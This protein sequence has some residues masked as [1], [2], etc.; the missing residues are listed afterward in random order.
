MNRIEPLGERAEAAEKHEVLSE[1]IERADVM[2][3]KLRCSEF[4][5]WILNRKLEK[6]ENTKAKG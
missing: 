4:S 5:R 1:I 6:A 2:F 3:A